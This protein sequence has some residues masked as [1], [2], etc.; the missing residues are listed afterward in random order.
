MFQ[1][2]PRVTTTQ[3]TRNTFGRTFHR[4]I[5]DNDVAVHFQEE[6]TFYCISLQPDIGL[7]I[8][9]SRDFP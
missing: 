2:L 4:F 7:D 8:A 6:P 9:L 1:Y 3:N 5:Q